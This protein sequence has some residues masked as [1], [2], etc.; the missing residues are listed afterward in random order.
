MADSLKANLK[1]AEFAVKDRPEKLS[2]L[3]WGQRRSG[4]ALE[5]PGEVRNIK[6]VLPD[7][8]GSMD[9]GAVEGQGSALYNPTYTVLIFTNSLMP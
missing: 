1:Y 9:Q 2:Q 8:A 7:V 5:T 3:G 6:L 4:T